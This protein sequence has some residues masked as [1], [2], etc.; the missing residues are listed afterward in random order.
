MKSICW[1]RQS[2]L[3]FGSLLLC[4]LFVGPWMNGRLPEV[5]SPEEIATDFSSQ[6]QDVEARLREL[7]IT[8]PKPTAPIAVFKPVVISDRLIFVSGHLPFDQ[9]GKVIV[10]KLGDSMTV[11]EGAAAARQCGIAILASLRQELGSLNR[12]QRLVK[13]TGMVNST[14]EFTEQPSAINGCSE[15]FRD[16]WGPEL[17]LGARAAVGMNSLPRGACLEIEMILELKK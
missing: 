4:C 8:L 7:G 13:T 12:I 9:Q 11:A 3:W 17:G 6:T 5:W 2:S 15:L 1:N 14:S 16:L 10:G